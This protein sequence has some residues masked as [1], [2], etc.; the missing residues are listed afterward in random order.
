MCMTHGSTLI[1]H[2]R[3]FQ[4]FILNADSRLYFWKQASAVP[5]YSGSGVVFP[6]P[7]IKGLSADVP[8]SDICLRQATLSFIAF[9]L[10]VY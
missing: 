7:G 1:F 9:A 3:F 2:F 5:S 10:S 4:T 8:L 6:M